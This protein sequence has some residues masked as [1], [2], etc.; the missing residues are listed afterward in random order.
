MN[1]KVLIVDDSST[2]RKLVSL[3][4]KFK[5]YNVMTKDNGKEGWDALQKEK[6]DLVIIDTLM[7]E[8]DGLELLSKIKADGKFEDMR[9]IILTEEG[10]EMN[11]QKGE[12]LGVNSCLV[13]P[14]QPQELLAKIEEFV[15]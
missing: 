5:G 1:E 11:E 2:I 9:C 6:F 10:D 12:A 14:F 4:L 15:K 8:M 13:K 7:P 3:T